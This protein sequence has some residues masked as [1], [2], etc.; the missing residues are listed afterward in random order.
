MNVVPGAMVK[1]PAPV[2]PSS[3]FVLPNAVPNV[4]VLAVADPLFTIILVIALVLLAALVPVDNDP[5]P[6]KYKFPHVKLLVPVPYEK[7]PISTLASAITFPDETVTSDVERVLKVSLN[8]NVH[9][10]AVLLKFTGPLK[11]CP[12]QNI[13]PPNPVVPPKDTVPEWERVI[14]VPHASNGVDAEG[15]LV[16]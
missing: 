6:V 13:Q 9:P 11:D 16:V 1:D 5:V 4:R 14:P 12:L 7:V 10:T 8:V 2:P 15:P 3:T